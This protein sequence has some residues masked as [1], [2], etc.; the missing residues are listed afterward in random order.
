MRYALSKFER[1]LKIGP[2]SS[3]YFHGLDYFLSLT[4]DNA[5]RS[6]SWAGGCQADNRLA[7]QVMFLYL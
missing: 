4:L 7:L 2:L 3:T 1:F 6:R 5:G